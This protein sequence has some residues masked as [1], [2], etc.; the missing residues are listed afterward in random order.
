MTLKGNAAIVTGG[1]RGIGRS[2]AL[3]L[4]R[5]GCSVTVAARRA[6]EVEE[7]AR[8]IDGA[9]TGAQGLAVALDLAAEGSIERL[10]DETVARFGTVGI[11][12]NNAGVLNPHRVPDITPEEWDRTMAVN[13]RCAFLLGQRVLEIMVRAG[14]GYIV[15]VSSPAGLHVSSLLAAY[16]VAKAG[17]A[18]LSQALFDEAK[19]HGV[20]VSTIYP[21]YVD[22][23]MLRDFD[24]AGA[25]ASTW[26]QPE[27]I[28]EC[29]L[30][31]LR[32][33]DRVIV[34]DLMPLAFGAER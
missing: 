1:G 29:V 24:G 21:G 2:I 12:V 8:E 11:L 28:A 33:S 14:R 34:K 9:G 15:N 17:V 6:R 18:A 26:A 10:V 5:E 23:E 7:V 32:Q 25:P 31:L 30:F 20:K 13:L 3:A 16:G 4:A 27:D 22:T 19:R